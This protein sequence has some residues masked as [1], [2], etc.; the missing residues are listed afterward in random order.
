QAFEESDIHKIIENCLLILQNQIKNN[1]SIKKNYADKPCL[2]RCNE[3]KIHQAVLNLL[4]NAAQAIEEKGTIT[5]Q[6]QNSGQKLYISIIDTGCGIKKENLTKVTDPFFT[7][8]D[9]GKGTGLGLSITQNIIDEHN[10]TLEIISEF[11]K[12]TTINITLP[13]SIEY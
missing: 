1:I 4:M 5:I 10:G 11:G 8:K 6:T 3:G 2:L 9:P 13:T 12:R 7:T